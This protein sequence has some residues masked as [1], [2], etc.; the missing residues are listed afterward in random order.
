LIF[1]RFF[2]LYFREGWHACTIDLIIFT[3]FCF[4]KLNYS[5]FD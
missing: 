5:D 2:E 4:V 3:Y 1:A